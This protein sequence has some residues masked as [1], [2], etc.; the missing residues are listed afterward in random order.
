MDSTLALPNLYFRYE[1]LAERVNILERRNSQQVCLARLQAEPRPGPRGSVRREV[2]LFKIVSKAN[3]K[4]KRSNNY[5]GDISEC[6]GASLVT[7][8][9]A[10]M[11]ILALCGHSS[12]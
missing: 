8:T 2:S 11:V 10:Y 4:R 1:V 5:R 6:F 9:R 12:G 7:R 3:R